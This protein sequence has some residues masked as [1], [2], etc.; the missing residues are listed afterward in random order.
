MKS[1][2]GEYSVSPES[3][4]PAAHHASAGCRA[5][6]ESARCEDCRLL[7]PVGEPALRSDAIV[8]GKL[9]PGVGAAGSSPVHDRL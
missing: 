9:A 7:R 2:L 5:A 4:R 8:L 1:L 6:E 3:R